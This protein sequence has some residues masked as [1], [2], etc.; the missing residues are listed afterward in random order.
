MFVTKDRYRHVQDARDG[1]PN[2][3][4]PAHIPARHI[5]NVMGPVGAG[6]LD[7]FPAVPVC[8][9]WPSP[10]RRLS[11]RAA[12]TIARMSARTASGRS[13]QA[14]MTVCRSPSIRPVLAPSA[15]HSAPPVAETGELSEDFGGGS[16]PASATAT[17]RELTR[18]IHVDRN[19]VA[20]VRAGTAQPLKRPKFR[21]CWRLLV[22][23]YTLAATGLRVRHT[24]FLI[25]FTKPLG[26]YKTI[27]YRQS[28]L[29]RSE[30]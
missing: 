30:R 21:Q 12:W 27:R 19:E 24:G 1:L 23:A 20:Q 29:S 26:P 22:P 9:W 14:S 28:W 25:V 16:S 5:L 8:W 13:G 17:E 6:G 3:T 18:I 7:R 15:P 10:H 11:Y 4:A 2:L